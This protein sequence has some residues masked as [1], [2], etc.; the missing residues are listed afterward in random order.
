M[1]RGL[2]RRGGKPRQVLA[3]LNSR[4]NSVSKASRMR[5]GR[6]RSVG[7]RR[8]SP[9]PRVLTCKPPAARRGRKRGPAK[10]GLNRSTRGRGAQ[11]PRKGMAES[12]AKRGVRKPR[13]YL[14]G[15]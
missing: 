2:H 4:A 13:C 8:R 3:L 15:G 5:Q 12:P 14:R 10:Q 6:S 11:A 7:T 9:A 1:A